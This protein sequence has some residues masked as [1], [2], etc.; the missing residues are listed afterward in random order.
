MLSVRYQNEPA[1]IE[2]M[3]K[4]DDP[5]TAWYVESSAVVA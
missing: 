5:D 4:A 1:R 2:F 3:A